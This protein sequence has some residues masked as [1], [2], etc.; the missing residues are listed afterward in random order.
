MEWVDWID[1]LWS[2]GWIAL[3][4]VLLAIIPTLVLSRKYLKV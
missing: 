3:L 1:G 2:I 4:G